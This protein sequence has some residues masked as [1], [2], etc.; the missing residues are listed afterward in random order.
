MTADRMVMATDRLVT[1]RRYRDAIRFG[2]VLWCGRIPSMH[3]RRA[4][5]R[6]VFH[7]RMAS[8]AVVWGGAEIWD[9]DKITIGEHSVIGHAAILDARCGIE[10]GA[11]VN[12][13]AGVWIWTCQHDPQSGSFALDCGPVAIEDYAWVSCR[14]VILPNTRIGR[15]AVV[16]AGAVVTKDVPPFAIVGGVPAKVIGQRNQALSYRPSDWYMP[17]Y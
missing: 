17:L 5:Y 1:A 14:T 12:L 8:T 11:N 10:I 6:Q 7:M 3:V 15:G 13:S 16:A 4:I 2:A 9:P